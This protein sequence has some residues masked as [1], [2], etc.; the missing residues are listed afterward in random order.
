MDKNSKYYAYAEKLYVLLEPSLKEF[1][2]KERLDYIDL[3]KRYEF[4]TRKENE[5]PHPNTQKD[6]LKRKRSDNTTPGGLAR[7]TLRN[8]D[9]HYNAV[10]ANNKK[11]ALIEII[12]NNFK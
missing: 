3:L 7:A 4:K 12:K 8:L 2:D 5:A 1:S 6:H 11:D 10:T 9:P